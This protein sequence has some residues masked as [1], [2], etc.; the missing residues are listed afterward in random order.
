[1]LNAV[2][3]TAGGRQSAESR[4]LLERKILAATAIVPL[5][6]IANSVNVVV[7]RIFVLP[8]GLGWFRDAWCIAALLLAANSTRVWTRRS[9]SSSR[10]PHHDLLVLIAEVVAIGALYGVLAVKAYP[11]L[12]H[13]EQML[14]IASLAGVIGSGAIALSTVRSVGFSWIL[15]NTI[16]MAWEF[17]RGGSMAD[18]V[19]LL[20]LVDYACVLMLGVAYH[21]ESFE[22]RVR[23]E[24]AAESER[25]VT[26][27][28]LDDFEA[29]SP[30]WL[31]ET[32]D[33]GA[34]VS[35]SR[36]FA[37]CAGMAE[38]EIEGLQLPE[39]LGLLGRDSYTEAAEV[40][41]EL[42]VNLATGVMFRG[43]E[44]AVQV[45][46]NW[47]TWSFSGKRMQ[48]DS[49]VH[50]WRGI[51]SDIT[52]ISHQRAEI[53]RLATTDELTG[54]ANRRAFNELLSTVIADR[55]LGESITLA[56]LD[57][58]NFKSVND[59]LGHQ[60][61]DLLLA[62]LAGRLR[63]QEDH[64]GVE[65]RQP[66]QV[67]CARLG[68]DEFALLLTGVDRPAVREI[69]AKCVLGIRRPFDLDGF[70]VECRASIGF[71]SIPDDAGTLDEL[72]VAADLALYGAK[73]HGRDRVRAFDRS[74]K[75]R[76]N[77][78]ATA[79]GQLRNALARR[80]F[81]VVYQPKVVIET[82]AVVGF[83]ALVRWAHPTK[84]IIAPADF[85]PVA[86][87]TG[88]IVGIG[89]Q[90]L[91]QA[92]CDAK[93]WPDRIQVAVN[94]S[95]VQLSSAALLSS[96]N[97]TLKETG[98]PASRLEFEVTESGLVE[99]EAIAALNEIKAL[100]ST[101][102]I[103]DFGTGYSSFATLRSLPLDRLKIDRSFVVDVATDQSNRSRSIVQAIVQLATTLDLVTVAEGVE[104]RAQSEALAA[105][106]CKELQ[107][108][109]E[110][111][112]MSAGEVGRYLARKRPAA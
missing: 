34:L 93:A 75:E 29:G 13:T 27:M 17:S 8:P 78:R 91:R 36:R 47:R 38:S 70:V 72:T 57:L 88:L 55:G 19:L 20:M 28:L 97:R 15:A 54:L 86:E 76:A 9:R 39:L 87:E 79:L 63:E 10:A 80:E 42:A 3:P 2:R 98:L 5:A 6:N 61:G 1:V 21:A 68:G 43:I 33:A 69:L 90:V 51:G 89:N 106:G 65:P 99:D 26:G 56:I 81:R 73:D 14:L 23:A 96:I 18:H 35:V 105:L 45:A 58:D 59:T 108:H 77:A 109:L 64:A 32:D 71:A 44:V 30:D 53:I 94:L 48:S 62:R 11:Q 82:G 12:S 74:L 110:A 95:P 52:E 46:G 25:L 7:L 83:E 49:L 22:A 107:G 102:A 40:S 4:I 31:W 84:G 37:E 103:D 111:R 66:H 41:D 100:G 101:V 112:P 24:L 85:I 67:R 92:C 60:A 104:T 50:G 16:G